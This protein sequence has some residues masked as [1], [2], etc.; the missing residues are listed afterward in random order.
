MIHQ[1][2]N[3]SGSAAA[4]AAASGPLAAPHSNEAREFLDLFTPLSQHRRLLLLAPVLA[5]VLA[6][7]V[8]F[9]MKPV[10][11]SSTVFLPPQQ[12]QS[13]AASALASLGALAGFA[14][15]G[16]I[17]SPA[18]QYVSLMQSDTV[19]DRMIDQ[20]HLMT[21]YKAKFRFEA[22]KDLDIHT[23]ILPGKKDGLI[24]VTVDD[25]DPERAAAMANQY[26]EELR[27]MTSLLAVTEAQQ[28]RAFFEKQLQDS[29]QRL[30]TAQMALQASGFNPGALNTEPKAA[31]D[32]YATLRAQL[33]AAEIKL[34]TL[35][36]NLANGA[37]E[38]SQQA[39]TV[40]ALRSR[41]ADAE[42]VSVPQGAGPDYIGKYRQFK[43]EETLFDLMAKQYEIARVDESREGGLIQVVDRAQ[44][45]EWKSRPKRALIAIGTA[46]VVGLLLPLGLIARARWKR[47]VMSATPIQ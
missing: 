33:T 6:L 9:L 29:K 42:R 10:F 23:Q 43:Y 26:V 19:A 2:D 5:G 28:R 17:K 1:E 15:G 30:T 47:F 40:A 36:G 37:P 31:A 45:A 34:E 18:D 38:V 4:A 14:G 8:T 41:L 13:G 24:T 35:R 16:A 32:A 11:V 20:F 3:T 25:H 12:Q 44:P 7:G 22:R 27:R 21:V 46:V 39:A